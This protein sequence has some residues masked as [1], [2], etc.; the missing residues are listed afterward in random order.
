[1]D[2]S[3][4]YRALADDTRRRIVLLLLRHN[5]CVSALARELRVSESAVSQHLKILRQAML[6]RGER[7]GYYMHYDIDR[8]RLR[9]LAR[10]IDAM[11]S[12]QRIDKD[13]ADLKKTGLRCSEELRRF[14]HSAPNVRVLP[15]APVDDAKDR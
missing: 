9:D 12:T 3:L 1:M 7:R 5:Y 10:E 15:M 4:L 11:A 2:N 8:E 6:L 14:C 13:D